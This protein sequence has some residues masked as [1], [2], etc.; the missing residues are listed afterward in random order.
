MNYSITAHKTG[1]Q[2]ELK[3]IPQWYSITL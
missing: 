1:S 3:T 2:A